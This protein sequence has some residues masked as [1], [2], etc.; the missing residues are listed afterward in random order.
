MAR[1]VPTVKIVAPDRY[2]REWVRINEADYDPGE[3]TRFDEREEAEPSEKLVDLLGTRQAN[4]L[5]RAGLTTIEAA[6]TYHRE[7]GDLTELEGVGDGTV[8]DL[9]QA[10]DA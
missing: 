7:E 2:D 8:E 5:A 10:A 1:R 9:T 4:A 3:H 6:M